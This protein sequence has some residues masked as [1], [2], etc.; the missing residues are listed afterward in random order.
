MNAVNWQSSSLLCCSHTCVFLKTQLKFYWKIIIHLEELIIRPYPDQLYSV[1][2]SH[3]FV[4]VMIPATLHT[5][6]KVYMELNYSKRESSHVST[7]FE[8]CNCLL[9]MQDDIS[10]SSV[11]ANRGFKIKY[12]KK[13]TADIKGWKLLG[14][15]NLMPLAGKQICAYI[16]TCKCVEETE[17]YW[18]LAKIQ[19]V[20]SL[21]NFF[22][23]P[24]TDLVTPWRDYSIRTVTH[25]HMY[26]YSCLPTVIQQEYVR[27]IRSF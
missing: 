9:G 12:L 8:L 1:S 19:Y 22:F 20:A 27:N 23:C 2:L 5:D 18:I 21:I 13:T 16:G 3:L 26:S 17:K 10:T 25:C 4:A 24:I 14:R 6:N 7:A 11:L 15:K